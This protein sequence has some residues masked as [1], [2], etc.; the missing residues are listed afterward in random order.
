M[1]GFYRL[2]KGESRYEFRCMGYRDSH[3]ARALFIQQGDDLVAVVGDKEIMPFI[4]NCTGYIAYLWGIGG[5][6]KTK[7]EVQLGG[8]V[9]GI[10]QG[11][12]A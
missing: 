7:P 3:D 4:L 5:P 2:G 11:F 12:S 8:K 10:Y 6:V 9:D 1:F